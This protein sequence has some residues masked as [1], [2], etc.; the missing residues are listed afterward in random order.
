MYEW[1][2]PPPLGIH[3]PPTTQTHLLDLIRLAVEEQVH[4][5]V[6]LAVAGDGPAEAQ[7][8]A[9]EEPVE[10]ADGEAALLV[11]G[12]VGGL[13]GVRGGGVGWAGSPRAYSW[14]HV[15]SCRLA[16][17][18]T[19]LV[20]GGDGHV[21]E[22]ERGVRVAQGDHGHVHVRRLV[23]GLLAC[24]VGSE[25]SNSILSHSDSSTTHPPTYIPGSPCA[26]PSPP[27]GAARGTAW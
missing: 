23:H 25:V 11:W 15:E 26:G 24:I 12:V 17:G 21:H 6:P 13:G 27:A 3:T 8:L 9:R 5:H 19:D 10:E 14:V 7:H 20:V 18:R 22:L 1:P 4:R 16:D 2:H